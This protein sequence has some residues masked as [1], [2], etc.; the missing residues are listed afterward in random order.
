MLFVAF[1]VGR[2][3]WA[4]TALKFHSCYV[5][6]SLVKK[7]NVELVKGVAKASL[8]G[9]VAIAVLWSERGDLLA[10]LGQTV[11]AGLSSAGRYRRTTRG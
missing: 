7:N 8:I 11:D 3:V 9:G 1:N 10:L 6:A 4:Y 5:T 2:K